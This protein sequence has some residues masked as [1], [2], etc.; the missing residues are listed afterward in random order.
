M[1]KIQFDV[2]VANGAS[3]DLAYDVLPVWR[4]NLFVLTNQNHR[5]MPK[6]NDILITGLVSRC[7]NYNQIFIF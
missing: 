7:L 5:Y 2:S 1:S 4:Y 6:L 3:I